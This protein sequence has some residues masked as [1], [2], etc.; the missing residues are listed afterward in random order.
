M[1]YFKSTDLPQVFDLAT[2]ALKERY[3]PN[4]FLD[5]S[6]Y[7]RQGFIVLEDMGKII[8]FV[9]GITVSSVEARIL[10]LAVSEERR[11]HGFGALLCRQFFQECASKGIRLISLEVRVSNHSALRFY[12]KLGFVAVGEIKEYYSDKEDGMAMQ[13]YL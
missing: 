13:L 12:E 4:I 5:L 10:M 6:P 1:R 11:G 3:N 2:R 8:G 7:W 9:F